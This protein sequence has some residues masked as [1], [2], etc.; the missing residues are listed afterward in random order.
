MSN[1]LKVAFV[2][3]S[4]DVQKSILFNLLKTLSKKKILITSPYRADF[5]IYGCYKNQEK[6]YHL[7]RFLK[8]KIKYQSIKNLL[9][10]FQMKIAHRLYKPITLFFGEETVR[11]NYI[12][13]DFSYTLNLGVTDKNHLRYKAWYEILDFS[14]NEVIGSTRTYDNHHVK[15]FGKIIKI[16]DLLKPQGVNFL[17]K[18]KK[19]CLFTS[20]FDEPR[21][22]FYNELS[23]NFIVDG[24]G[25]YFN[26]NLRS[27]DDDKNKKIDVMKD[28]GFNLC[29]ENT[30]YPGFWNSRVCESFIAK[31]LP[32]TWAHQS[33]NL[34]FNDKAF[35]NLN[36]YF[37]DNFRGIIES[38]QDDIFLNKYTSEPMLLK[39]PTLKEEITFAENILKCF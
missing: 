27:P 24:Y 15:R 29:P 1:Y 11:H 39:P 36:D 25:P 3:T 14:S 37:I 12:K 22:T 17:K 20:N 19:I 8:R 9:D 28:Y 2:W 10:L 4:P 7:H 16:E 5:I 32:I 13:T 21:R 31:C 18:N 35:I 6:T 26:K 38:L 30:I 33:I 34:D 23:K